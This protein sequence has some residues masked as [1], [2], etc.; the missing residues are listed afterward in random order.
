M[1]IANGLGLV[2]QII[3]LSWILKIEKKCDCSKDWRRDYMKYMS[4]IGI[5]LPFLIVFLTVF[6]RQKLTN[7]ILGLGNHG[8]K[9]MGVTA[10]IIALA[11]LVNLFSILTYIPSLKKRGCT[12][13]IEDD[14]RD[15]F[16]F[17]WTLIGLI[18]T[19]VASGAAG[20]M[21]TRK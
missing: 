9:A 11:G 19:I 13:A 4:I 7:G 15:N 16:I 1:L 6:M 2:V 8:V 12:C 10:V 20:F 21:L 17:W 14:W 18:L 5:A 3:V